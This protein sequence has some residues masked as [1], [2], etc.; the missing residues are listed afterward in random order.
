MSTVRKLT[1]KAKV[2]KSKPNM[3]QR[4]DAKARA[5]RKKKADLAKAKAKR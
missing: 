4:L 5:V 1:G 2:G 3:Q